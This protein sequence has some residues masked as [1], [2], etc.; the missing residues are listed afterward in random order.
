MA[1]PDPIRGTFWQGEAPP[2]TVL[3]LV[4]D[5]GTA[6]KLIDPVYGIDQ[7]DVKLYCVDDPLETALFQDTYT[8]GELSTKVFQTLQTDGY[9]FDDVGYN[10]LLKHD[11]DDFADCVGGRS[12]MLDIKVTC[13]A[14]QPQQHPVDLR[15]VGAGL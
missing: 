10:V 8:G 6:L 14:Q 5:D 9:A 1:A 11:A 13:A 15:C 3:R 7:I 12:Y 2:P 4:A